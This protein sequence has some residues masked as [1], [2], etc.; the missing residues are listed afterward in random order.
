MADD[1]VR[2]QAIPRH[3]STSGHVVSERSVSRAPSAVAAAAEKRQAAAA[4]LAAAD[5]TTKP[6][7]AAAPAAVATPVVTGGAGLAAARQ[8]A[9]GGLYGVL[10][11]NMAVFGSVLLS[12]LLES[13]LSVFAH[14]ALAIELFALFPL[15][16]RHAGAFYPDLYYQCAW[17]SVSHTFIHPC[18][19]SIRG[20]P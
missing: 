18:H 1:P 11:L 12:S 2:T 19:D 16:C 8:P 7:G 9:P 10:S 15:W 4:A 20:L 14:L 5:G 6:E 17:G 13:D 3:D